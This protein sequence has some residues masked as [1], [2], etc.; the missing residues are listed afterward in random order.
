MQEVTLKHRSLS[1]TEWVDVLKESIESRVID[2]V[3]FP[4]F[5][6]DAIQNQFVGSS[7]KSTLDEA[8]QFYV[9]LKGYSEALGMPIEY[10]R[11]RILDFGCGWGRFLRLFWRDVQ[12]SNLI[13]VDIDPT[14][15]SE[16]I[17]AGVQADLRVIS[18]TGALPFPDNHF[19]HIF[20]YSVFTHLP[21][22]V[23]LHW[24]AE[25]ARV[26]KP[27][28]VFVCTT[29]PGRF[30]DFIAEIPEDAPSAWHA[31][32]KRAAGDIASAKAKF[33]AGSFIYIPTGGGD[34][35]DEAIYGDAIIPQSYI[36]ENWSKYFKLRAYIDD[37]SRFWQAVVIGQT[38]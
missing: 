23:H 18:P 31:G 16:C 12:P 9:T 7:N 33:A 3:T 30:L 17:A 14:I 37:P 26:A 22:Q 32:L 8:L 20:A 4:R 6:S 28:C 15:I 34:Y 11:S 5:P 27:G 24:L 38:G 13:G 35:R 29:E 25:L 2:G 19:S 21:E 10:D 36:K 1:D